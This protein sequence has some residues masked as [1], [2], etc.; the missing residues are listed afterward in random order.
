MATNRKPGNPAGNDDDWNA[1]VVEDLEAPAY[2]QLRLYS[3]DWTFETIASQI[4]Q[5]NIDLDPDFQR[6]NVW[7]DERRSRL[8][9]SLII[10]IPVPQIF[11][12]EDL[13]RKR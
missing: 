9:E 8:I 1:D 12:A 11:L 3:R 4:E 2:E 10:G 13:K 5:G 7:T 6:K